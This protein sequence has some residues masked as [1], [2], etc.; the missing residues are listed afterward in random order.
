MKHLAPFYMKPVRFGHRLLRINHYPAKKWVRV[1]LGNEME[2]VVVGIRQLQNGV[3]ENYGEDGT[4]W[5]PK[6]YTLALVVVFSPYK[7]PV[8]VLPLDAHEVMPQ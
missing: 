8:Y 3:C 1:S 4:V 7:N 2:G 5:H 6:S